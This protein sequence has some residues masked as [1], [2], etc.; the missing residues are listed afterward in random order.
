MAKVYSCTL[1]TATCKTFHE[2][3]AAC[4][5]ADG[6]QAY[7]L[8]LHE[9]QHGPASAACSNLGMV[10]SGSRPGQTL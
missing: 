2:L 10:A 6:L 8:T 5:A 7:M 1:C 3:L 4:G 9:M